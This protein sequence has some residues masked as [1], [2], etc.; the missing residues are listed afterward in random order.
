MRRRSGIDSPWQCGPQRLDNVGGRA[1]S[2]APKDHCHEET[3]TRCTGPRGLGHRPRLHGHERLLLEPRRCRSRCAPSIGRIELGVNF[4]DTADMYGPFTNE[5]LVGRAS[6]AA[7]TASSSPR[8]SA[9]A[10]D[11][12]GNRF[13]DGRPDYVREAVEA[14]LK[15]L[16]IDCI[17]LYYQHRVDPT[18]PIEDTVGA[19]AELVKAG[20]V[21]YL[22]LER[23]RA[24][25]HPSGPTRCTRSPRCRPS[26]RSGPATR[27][28]RARRPA[29]SS[30][31]ASSPTARWAA[32]S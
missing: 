22:G 7:A 6:R 25:D 24:A 5:E 18:V 11:D 8:N 31:S 3:S 27:K 19:M 20:K 17:D 2:A 12:K 9:T 21:R 15:R 26:I 28:A 29:A 32:A 10:P 16:G 4:L 1:G 13:V 30:A 14:S 23:G